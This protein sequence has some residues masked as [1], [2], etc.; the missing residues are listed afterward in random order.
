MYGL[1]LISA[2][3]ITGALILLRTVLQRRYVGAN[4]L[5]ER[6]RFCFTRAVHHKPII[7]HLFQD[8]LHDRCM[9]AS[10][11]CC[12]GDT[13]LR[14]LGVLTSRLLVVLRSKVFLSFVQLMIF[15]LAL[16]LLS[17]VLHI[18]VIVRSLR[19]AR[20]ESYSSS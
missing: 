4:I 15:R 19:S 12:T 6:A 17:C 16:L 7:T 14:M 20:Q 3:V 11:I 18:F 10:M 13:L 1:P 5:K 9:S 8:F 2:C